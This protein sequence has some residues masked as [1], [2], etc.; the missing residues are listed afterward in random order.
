MKN[1]KPLTN[2]QPTTTADELLDMDQAIALL[3]TT[4]PT[5][6]RWVRAGK[7]KGM[8]AGRQWRF[9]RADVER[10]IKGQQPRIELVAD[11]QP[12]IAALIAKL[13]AVGAKANGVEAGEPVAKA[14]DS[15]WRCGPPIYISNHKPMVNI[16]NCTCGTEWM[17]CCTRP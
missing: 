9:Y 5:F 17:A 15:D 1:Q 14:V 3:K 2:P 13:T 7:I 12:L 11:I 6:Y 8:K 10:F 4:R 16:R